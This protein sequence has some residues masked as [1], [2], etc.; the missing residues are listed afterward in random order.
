VLSHVRPRELSCNANETH[1]IDLLFLSRQ[2]ERDKL[3]E[4]RR[5]LE[6]RLEGCEAELKD[7]EEELFLQLERSLRLEDEVDRARQEREACLEARERLEREQASA[8]RQL[9]I[10]AA[11][12]E[13]TRR[14]LERARQEV[15][16][17]ATA[18][19][20]ERDALEREVSLRFLPDDSL[21]GWIGGLQGGATRGGERRERETL[22]T[23]LL[24]RWHSFHCLP[25]TLSRLQRLIERDL[26]C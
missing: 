9:Q 8:L 2:A 19:R 20:A 17:Q 22:L 6:R 15:V 1:R 12:N 14:S 3:E 4:T 13:I 18:I 10:Q 24:T 23:Y 11:Q 26:S 25:P 7:K 5:Q 16:K 21:G